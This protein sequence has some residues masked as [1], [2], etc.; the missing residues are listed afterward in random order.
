MKT[1]IQT[2]IFLGE[3]TQILVLHNAFSVKLILMILDSRKFRKSREK[4]FH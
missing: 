2:E 1:S 4:H 3:V